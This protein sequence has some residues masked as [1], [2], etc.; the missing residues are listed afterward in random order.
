VSTFVAPV[1]HSQTE[2]TTGFSYA[3]AEEEIRERLVD[4]LDVLAAGLVMG[5]GDLSGRDTDTLRLTHFTGLGYAESFAAMATET[6]AI[7]A[8]AY[9]ADNDTVS[10]GRYGLAKEQSYQSSI[11]G[12]ARQ[13]GLAKMVSMVPDSW[14]ATLRANCATVISTFSSVVGTS[15]AVWSFD[16]EL[17]LIAYFHETEGYDPAVHGA[18]VT[19]RAPEQFS[20]L[21]EAI[22]NEPG[23]QG[24]AELMASL[25]GLAAAPQGGMNFLGLRNFSS[26]DVI[27][28]G[29]D[30]I[31]GA[32]LPGA[33]AWCVASAPPPVQDP[34][35]AMFLP[36]FG[37]TIEERSRPDEAVARF[38]ANAWFGVAKRSPLLFPQVRI[39]SINA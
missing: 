24:S 12:S 13:I 25:L 4:K 20:Q 14:L 29:G 18:P 16:D 32:Y 3:F 15:G 2:S 38:T 11:L 28:A 6:E 39:R 23:L 30:H 26:H 7:V 1:T 10:I 33:V 31:G 9:E 27:T 8:S 37:L 19:W 17:D 5:V 35:R 22:R 36:E 34:A 21:R